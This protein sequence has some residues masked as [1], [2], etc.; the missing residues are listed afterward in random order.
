MIF[1]ELE[2]LYSEIDNE[3]AVK[4]FNAHSS[5]LAAQEFEVALKREKND[6]A[7]F[8]F[9]FTRLEKRIQDLFDNLV[10]IKNTTAIDDKDKNSWRLMKKKKLDLMD[11]VSFFAQAGSA[12]Y[13]LIYNYK[14]KRDGVA[15]GDMASGINI[16]TILADMKRLYNDLDN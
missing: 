14:K 1:D 12:N 16:L 9:I 13:N 4:E 10:T 5:G 6:Q 2:I 3:Y 7:Y 11:K 15:H 8:L